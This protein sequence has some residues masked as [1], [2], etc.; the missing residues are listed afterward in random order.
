MTWLLPCLIEWHSQP[1]PAASMVDLG[2]RLQGL[3]LYH[4]DPDWLASIL[5]TIEFKDP[6]SLAPLTEHHDG[7]FMEARLETP[8]GLKILQSPFGD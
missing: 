2:C 1:H 4:P 6:I 5:G 3:T 7:P 8:V